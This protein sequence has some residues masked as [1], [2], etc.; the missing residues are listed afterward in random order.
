MKRSVLLSI[1]ACF[2]AFSLSAQ[3]IEG[4]RLAWDRG[5]EVKIAHHGNYARIIMLEDNSFLATFEHAGSACLSSSSDLFNWSSPRPIIS[6]HHGWSGGLDWHVHVAN[7][8]LCLTKDGT[9]LLAVNYRPSGPVNYPF[10]I[11]L[12]RSEDGGVTW[13]SPDV[14]YCAGLDF[15]NGCWEPSFLQLPDGRIHLYFANEGPYTHSEEQEISVMTSDDDGRTWSEPQTVSFRR[16]HRDGMPVAALLGNEII[17]AIEDNADGKFKPYTVRTAVSDAWTETIDG[18]SAFRKRALADHVEMFVYMGAPYIAVLHSGE[19]LLSYQTTEGRHGDWDLS[20]ME[21]AVSDSA[22]VDFTKRTRPFDVPDGRSG[23]WNSLCLIDDNTV[24][25]V[26][27]TDKDGIVAPYVI[28]GRL[29]R[30]A[31]ISEGSDSLEHM[32]VGSVSRDHLAVG[33]GRRKGA[34]VF[35]ARVSDTDV[36]AGD[37]VDFMIDL[38]GNLNALPQ[39]GV[40]KVSL[41][42]NG[43]F[44]QAYEGRDGRW[45]PRTISAARTEVTR[46]PSGY[47]IKLVMRFGG[48][49]I[50]DVRVSAAHR[51]A[52]SN[53]DTYTE[54]LVHSDPDIPSTWL[55]MSTQH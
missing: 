25:A 7:P 20:C 15:N 34:Y 13:S 14:L 23:K 27:S 1:F 12:C 21:V 52:A 48:R 24:A 5:S 44:T 53:G 50:E 45:L 31:T 46:T 26:S 33:V 54:H 28:K 29:I 47:T 38:T 35:N 55:S 11:V 40:F 16:N 43:R 37:G 36:T 6:S 42:H 32:F 8:E 17:L 2:A 22:A 4:L 9:L 10:S 49:R 41:D 3:A 18:K 39:K 51:N 19:T 30:P